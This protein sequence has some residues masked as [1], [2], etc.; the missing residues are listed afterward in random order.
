MNPAMLKQ[1]VHLLLERRNLFTLGIGLLIL[2]VLAIFVTLPA[3][4]KVEDLE[5]QLPLSRQKLE[6][7]RELGTLVAVLKAKRRELQA[8][9]F[10]Q[11]GDE[12]EG[13]SSVAESVSNPVVVLLKVAHHHRVDPGGPRLVVPE[14]ASQAEN[15]ELWIDLRGGLTALQGA[16]GD[17]FNLPFV[18]E[19]KQLGLWRDDEDFVLSM[20]LVISGE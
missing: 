5:R 6:Q 10:P 20:V 18:V 9:L 3:F 13:D 17:I 14:Q 16:A 12:G 19:A 2:V 11:T 8:L 7:M 4:R 1:N 15:M